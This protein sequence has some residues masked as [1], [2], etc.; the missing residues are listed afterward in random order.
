M[1]PKIGSESPYVEYFIPVAL[2]GQYYIEMISGPIGSTF[3]IFFADLS[4]YN[5]KHF[6]FYG[7]NII[8]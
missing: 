7:M 3:S 6:I 8:E 2:Y 5:N 1:E 4:V